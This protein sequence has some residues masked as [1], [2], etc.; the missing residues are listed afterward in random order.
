L[1]AVGES[2]NELIAV[3]RKRGSCVEEIGVSIQE[4]E[5]KVC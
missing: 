2:F 1:I 5:E 4:N 3:G